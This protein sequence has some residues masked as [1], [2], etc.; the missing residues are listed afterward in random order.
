MGMTGEA[1][2]RLTTLLQELA[3][4]CCPGR[5]ALTLEGGYDHTALSD[6]V[7]SVLSSLIRGDGRA[8]PERSPR[9]RE[10]V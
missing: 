6:G 2:G 8:E 9:G 10:R 5:I 3:G 1:Y 4:N 7:A